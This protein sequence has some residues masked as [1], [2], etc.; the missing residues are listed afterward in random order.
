MGRLYA[1]AVPKGLMLRIGNMWR[2]NVVGRK[3]EELALER[4]PPFAGEQNR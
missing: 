1:F 2:A 4:R 3:R